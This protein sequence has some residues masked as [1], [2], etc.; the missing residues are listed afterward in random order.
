MPELELAIAASVRTER[1][2]RKWRQVDLA[3]HL[4]CSLSQVSDLEL[5]KRAIHA[6]ELPRLCRVLNISFFTLIKGAEPGDILALLPAT[7]PSL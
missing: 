4:G 2:R 6:N 5:N 3:Q 7:D 1:N